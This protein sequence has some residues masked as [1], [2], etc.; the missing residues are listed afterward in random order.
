MISI[1]GTFVG[2][3]GLFLLAVS[4]ITDGLKLA[5]GDALKDVLARSTST[6]FRGLVS[7][8]VVTGIVQSSSAVTVATIGFV[9]AG[10]LT[11]VQSLGVI[12]GANVGT[13]VTGWIVAAVGFDFRIEAVALPMIGLGMFARILR[14]ST[15][16]AAIGEA[17]AGFGLFFIGVEVLKQAFESFSAT[18]DVAGF[19][20]QGGLGIVLYLL[21]GF[22]MTVVSQ[23]SSAA[24]AITL[25]AAT[26]GVLGINAAAAMVVGANI[27]T[28]STAA[29]AVVGATPNAR[30]VAAA[31]VA[32]NLLTGAVAV[33]LLPLM[34]WLVRE[35]G[36]VLGLAD[37]PAVTLALFHT[38]FNVLGVALMWPLTPRLARY[39]SG[40]FSSESERLGRPEFLDHNALANP[41]LAVRALRLELARVLRLSREVVAAS[42]SREITAVGP[43]A[44]RLAA[45]ELLIDAIEGFV[46][47]L[48]LERLPANYGG[49]L[50]ILLRVTG[51]LED[52]VGLVRDVDRHRA[53]IQSIVALRPA[54]EEIS[55]FEVAIITQLEQCDPDRPDFDVASVDAGYDALRSRWHQLKDDL[56]A[57][58]AGRQLP[59]ARLN[60]ATEGL[61]DYLK[62]AEQISKASV[63]LHTLLSADKSADTSGPRAEATEA[64]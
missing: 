16:V 37:V 24:I 41:T 23:S 17:L 62:M 2:G 40:R 44:A 18:V 61:R 60:S 5:A 31:H 54:G 7:G 53:D 14:P 20:P 13:T 39:L 22:F 57:K 29:F 58:A 47:R 8:I 12:Y 55:A 33:I 3:L 43:P 9:N 28:T 64:A 30:R 51:Y 42:L 59:I 38:V 34:L 6:R 25:T 45:I 32:F 4:M 11:L 50:S 36:E 35:T 15:R 27:G 56:L 10:L 1:V 48:E 21:L 52:T 63:R 19:A 26:G 46:E 49:S